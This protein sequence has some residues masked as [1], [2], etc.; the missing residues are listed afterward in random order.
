[1]HV[2]GPISTPVTIDS[3]AAAYRATPQ[4]STGM[5]PNM[6]MLGREV[7]LRAEIMFGSLTSISM[8]SEP[9]V[10]YGEY[11]DQLRCKMQPLIDPIMN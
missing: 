9:V 7:R 5:T 1:M 8:I 11:L 4:K 3:L 10:S 2:L 6:L